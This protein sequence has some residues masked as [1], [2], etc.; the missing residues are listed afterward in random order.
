MV[1]VVRGRSSA[2]ARHNHYSPN[3]PSYGSAGL[4][5]SVTRALLM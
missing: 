4:D 1:F 2:A 5:S 3:P